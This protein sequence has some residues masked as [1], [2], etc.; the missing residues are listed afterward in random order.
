M[1]L[2]EIYHKSIEVGIANDWRGRDAV[3]AILD[4][5]RKDSSEP[6]F[7]KD[8]LFNPYGD[9]RIAVG[10]PDTDITAMVVGID[11]GPNELLMAATM[12]QM[13]KRVD[14]CFCHHTSCINRG[15]YYYDDIIEHHRSSLAE[16]GV[17]AEKYDPA[18]DEWISKIEYRWKLDTMNAA[19]NLDI[20]LVN[21]HTPCDLMHV[22]HT[23]AVFERNSDATLGDIAAELNEVEEI[24]TT[25]YEEVIVHGDSDSKP[26]LVYNPT[27]AGWRPPLSMFEMACEVGINSAVFVSPDENFFAMSR[28]YNV[29]IVELPHN[30]NDNHG[31]NL[32]LDEIEKVQPMTIYDA[33][34]FR[35]VRRV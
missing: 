25:P 11:I 32:M 13:G 5:A 26:G 34:N 12:R 16:V 19:R 24:K 28:K 35:R 29:N 3:D 27:G 9:S 7:D 23:L 10:D 17:P 30:S 2:N 22:G 8:R 1:T 33:H 4:K 20:P 31:I 15:L 21:V 18:V 14:L 6:G